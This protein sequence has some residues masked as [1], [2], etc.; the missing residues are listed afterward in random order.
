MLYVDACK[1]HHKQSLLEI[2]KGP[3]VRPAEWK[4]AFHLI[5]DSRLPQKDFFLH[6]FI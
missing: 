2:W 3:S 6:K 4:K 5:L 1:I